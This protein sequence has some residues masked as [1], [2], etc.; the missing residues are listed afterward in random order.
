MLA[1]KEKE[2]LVRE[3]QERQRRLEEIRQLKD[4][5]ERERREQE[6][7]LRQVLIALLLQPPTL[8]WSS[9]LHSHTHH[10]THRSKSVSRRSRRRSRRRSGRRRRSGKWRS[11]ARRPSAGTRPRSA[12]PPAR[13][14]P[15]TSTGS[16]QT[17]LVATQAPSLTFTLSRLFVCRA[18]QRG[19]TAQNFAEEE[20]PAEAQA[21]LDSESLEEAYVLY[22]Q[23]QPWCGA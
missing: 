19:A 7:L 8:I 15:T 16:P 4:K 23:P 22:A 20:V 14:S 5:Q 21:S 18:I 1:I 3:E 12:C 2:R 11:S 6:E 10:R 13:P 17:P 9:Y